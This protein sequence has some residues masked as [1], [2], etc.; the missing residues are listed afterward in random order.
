MAQPFTHPLADVHSSN[1]G[2]DTRIWQFVVVLAGAEIG[3]DCNI[4]SHCFV[5]NDVVI[6]DRVT[7][8]SGVQLWDGL[9]VGHD[10]FIGPNATFAKDFFQVGKGT[11][12]RLLQT[13]VDDGATIG[14]GATVLPGITAVALP[15]HT[16]GHSGYRI[17]SGKQSLLVIGDLAHSAV[18]SLAEP[19]WPGRCL[20]ELIDAG[21]EFDFDRTQVL[22]TPQPEAALVFF[23]LH[24]RPG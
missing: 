19:E 14:A 4:C 1:I 16:P 7:V 2:A 12:E 24:G 9:R 21:Q 23:G 8:K 17:T 13:L 18:L 20:D 15:G 22:R 11:S 5:E 3:Q 6:G 10:V